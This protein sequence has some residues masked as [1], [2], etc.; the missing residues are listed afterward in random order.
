MGMVDDSSGGLGGVLHDL[1]DLHHDACLRLHPDPEMLAGQL[2]DRQLGDDYS[3]WS[4]AIGQYADVLG[5]VGLAAYRRLLEAKWADVPFRGPGPSDELG[6]EDKSDGARERR[7]YWRAVLG[8][9]ERLERQAGD[10]EA[11]AAVLAR[12]LSHPYHYLEIATIYQEAGRPEQA[13]AWAERGLRDYPH[14]PDSRLRDFVTEA[15]HRAGR[16]AEAMELAWVGFQA[17]PDLG[18][19]KEL[20]AHAEAAGEWPHW[21]GRALEHIRERLKRAAAEVERGTWRQMPPDRSVLV[22]IYL[23]EGDVEAAWRE[24]REGGCSSGLW[25]ELAARR[26]A[27]R[28]EE[29]LPIYQREVEPA[30][31]TK[32]YDGYVRA[33]D[34][35]R[36]VKALL[37]RLGRE[38]EFAPYLAEV[39]ARHRRKRNFQALTTNI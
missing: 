15:Y 8:L 4:D 18:G 7:Y 21:R 34:Y 35:L 20:K 30:I 11:L 3:V 14:R 37:V 10:V 17:S 9:M 22:S 12:D 28:P 25:L 33:A 6:D 19:Y 23:W 39:R 36:K 38:E 31:E 5:E 24:A 1:R 32:T 16:H 26:E 13:L 2:L 29:A 27:E